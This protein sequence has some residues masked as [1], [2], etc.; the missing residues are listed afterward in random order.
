GWLTAEYNGM[1][2]LEHSGLLS[3][4]YAD[5]VLL[6]ETGHGLVLLYNINSMPSALLAFPQVKA[7]LIDIITGSQPPAN[8]FTVQTYSLIISLIVLLSVLLAL[9][10]LTH[11]SQWPQRQGQTAF[12]RLLPGLAWKFTPLIILLLLPP[13]TAFSGRVFSSGQ[14][15]RFMPDIYLWLGA[16]GILGSINGLARL[17]LYKRVPPIKRR[18]QNNQ[19]TDN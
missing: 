12:I 6:P 2:M 8:S 10:S 16:V 5:M 14:L 4:Y 3:V 19:Q 17:Y 11:L 13:L 18:T 15:F 1:P 9:R 7:G